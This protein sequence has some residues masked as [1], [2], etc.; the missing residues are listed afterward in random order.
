MT[1][2]ITI[3]IQIMS[4]FD[5]FGGVFGLLLKPNN[6]T[7]FFGY[8]LGFNNENKIFISQFYFILIH[9]YNYIYL[10]NY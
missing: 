6:D 1:K 7:F 10:I 8:V 5:L 2:A 9:F 4:L 3:L